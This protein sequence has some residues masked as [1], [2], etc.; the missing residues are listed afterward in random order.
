MIKD[1]ILSAQSNL[2][3][4]KER[5]KKL[6]IDIKETFYNK[7]DYW[8]DDSPRKP[9]DEK[10]KMQAA[11]CL[12]QGASERYS[13]DLDLRKAENWISRDNRV[14]IDYWIV[15]QERFKDNGSIPPTIVIHK[16][17]IKLLQ[18]ECKKL[19]ITEV[20]SSFRPKTLLGFE[21][22]LNNTS[23]DYILELMFDS[24]E[25]I[26]ERIHLVTD[27]NLYLK[28]IVVIFP[29]SPKFNLGNI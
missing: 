8:A 3:R 27:K 1:E 25:E 22:W 13:F 5:Y 16:K 12:A 24:E 21:D 23:V 10:A 28:D 4:L 9:R 11:L 17:N 15:N 7:E 26:S 6:V 19:W 14:K 20:G 18:D 2:K 29:K